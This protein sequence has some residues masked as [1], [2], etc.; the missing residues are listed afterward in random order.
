VTAPASASERGSAA[1]L[2]TDASAPLDAAV[3]LVFWDVV[4][5]RRLMLDDP[6][7]L[8]V[9]EGDEFRVEV[10]LNRPA[11]VYLIWIDSEGNI[12]PVHPWEPGSDWKLPGPEEATPALTLPAGGDVLP[13]R[14]PAGVETL[15]LLARDDEPLS[16]G[17]HEDFRGWLPARFRPLGPLSNPA[18]PRWREW[19]EEECET[20]G[21]V[22]GFG[23]AR[24]A[25]DPLFQLDTLLRER[26]GPRFRLVQAVSFTN[27][28]QKGTQS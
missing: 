15:V 3:S 14:G 9:K 21:G 5:K 18:Q 6:G 27:L 12:S 23:P 7:V 24:P 10:R 28:G 8:P 11:F 1:A 25:A 20:G 22:R 19:R 4:Q 17:E 26:L 2:S 13:I 16:L